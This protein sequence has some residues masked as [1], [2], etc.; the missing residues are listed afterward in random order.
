MA[1]NVST[2]LLAKAE[3]RSVWRGKNCRD[4]SAS[5]EWHLSYLSIVPPFG[6]GWRV[7]CEE[8]PIA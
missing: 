3:Q 5:I 1:L 6:V 8:L 4:M 2:I 7:V